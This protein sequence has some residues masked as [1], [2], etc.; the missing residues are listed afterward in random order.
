MASKPAAR[1]VEPGGLIVSRING[2]LQA[3]SCLLPHTAV[4]AS[5]DAEAVRA[6]RSIR[7]LHPELVDSRSPVTVLAL[8]LEPVY[9]VFAI[10]GNPIHVAF[11]FV[12]LGQFPLLFPTGF[13]WSI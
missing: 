6:W 11:W 9:G 12:L 7:V 2:E 13:F 10:S 8:E 3:V 5:D 1:S 4:V